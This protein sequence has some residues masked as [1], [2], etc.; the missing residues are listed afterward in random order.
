[1]DWRGWYAGELERERGDFVVYLAV[2]LV[3]A[4]CLALGIWQARRR[5]LAHEAAVAARQ[6]AAADL[7]ALIDA[8]WRGAASP[9]LAELKARVTAERPLGGAATKLLALEGL[10][11]VAAGDLALA[12]AHVGELDALLAGRL[13]HARALRGALAAATAGERGGDP[14]EAMDELTRALDAGL[15]HPDLRGWRGV[16]RAAEGLA[17]APLA[18]E[19]LADLEA[20]ASRRPLRPAEEAAR[21]RAR[22]ALARTA[23]EAA[24]RR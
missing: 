4:L 11:A 17:A 13:P 20:A 16:A 18:L 12:R 19:A 10:A 3:A 8:A 6:E 22:A 5:A 15:V 9:T 2:G 21:A 14:H 23:L 1:M 24:G 7:E